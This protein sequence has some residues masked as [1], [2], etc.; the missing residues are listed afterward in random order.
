[1]GDREQLWYQKRNTLVFVFG[2]LFVL[3]ALTLSV[4]DTRSVDRIE[5]QAST[6]LPDVGPENSLQSANIQQILP[7]PDS[8][9]TSRAVA[10]NAEEPTSISDE[11]YEVVKVVDGDTIDVDI[12]G[13]IERLRLIGIDTPETVDPRK[14]VQCFGREASD[15]TKALLQGT[16]VRLEADPSQGERDKYGRLLRYVFMED[17]TN[18]N[19]L[20]IAE[21][22]AH[23]YTYDM[24]YRYQAAFR[25]AQNTAREKKRGLWGASCVHDDGTDTVSLT[26]LDTQA[27][28]PA[29]G[30]TIKGNISRTGE[31]IYHMPGCDSY[32]KTVISETQGERWFCSEAEARAAGWRKARNCE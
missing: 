9:T 26:Q 3:A 19:L 4:A 6:R 32:E 21:G 12:D 23:E 5:Q 31:K 2:L 14:P 15:K 24:P 29:S 10:S 13:T 28:I 16:H 25:A 18:V 27:A 11:R 7:T 22:Y 8:A 20:L 17:G 30:C 1:M